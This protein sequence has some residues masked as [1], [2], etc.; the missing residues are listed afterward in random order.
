MT[1]H[2]PNVHAERGL[3]ILILRRA[4]DLLAGILDN[5]DDDLHRLDG[6]A[7]LYHVATWLD[8]LPMTDPAF[9]ARAEIAERLDPDDQRRVAVQ[10][11]AEIRTIGAMG[12]DDLAWYDLGSVGQSTIRA[13]VNDWVT[14]P[15]IADLF[16]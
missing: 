9:A 13:Q 5:P 4:D 14:L 10:L 15:G 3:A 8:R 6:N 16:A 7:C 12:A 1:T 11:G 2:L